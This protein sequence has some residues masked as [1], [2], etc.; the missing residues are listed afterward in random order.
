MG[1]NLLSNEVLKAAKEEL[2]HYPLKIDLNK[3][4]HIFNQK[5]GSD[6]L[7][8]IRTLLSFLVA[9]RH[10]PEIKGIFCMGIDLIGSSNLFL[11]LLP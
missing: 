6:M 2:S 10:L 11:N 4:L 1:Y 8:N 7:R 3:P 9:V 5:K